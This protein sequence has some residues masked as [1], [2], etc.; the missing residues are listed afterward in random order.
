MSNL[1][2]PTVGLHTRYFG[3]CQKRSKSSWL[4]FK[5]KCFQKISCNNFKSR[6]SLNNE[7]TSLSSGNVEAAGG[8]NL[9]CREDPQRTSI[10]GWNQWLELPSYK[11]WPGSTLA[12][13]KKSATTLIW[14]SLLLIAIN[15][16]YLVRMCCNLSW[17]F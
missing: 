6:K 2:N 16:F 14:N 12:L 17:A 4:S 5:E 11:R 10:V 7:E 9:R 15:L 8:S 3:S 1:L 13:G